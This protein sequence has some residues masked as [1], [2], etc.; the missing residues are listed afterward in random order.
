MS[1]CSRKFFLLFKSIVCRT[2]IY[3]MK[4]YVENE[5]RYFWGVVDDDDGGGLKHAVYERKKTF[6]GPSGSVDG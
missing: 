5:N 6:F 2:S 3:K 4:I 1:G